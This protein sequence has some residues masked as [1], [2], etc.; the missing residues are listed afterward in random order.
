MPIHMFSQCSAVR[1]ELFK[2]FVGFD[3]FRIHF[4]SQKEI[5][6]SAPLCGVALCE[7]SDESNNC[8]ESCYASSS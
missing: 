4:G 8:G 5:D 1:G 6:R 7:H 3:N 2:L